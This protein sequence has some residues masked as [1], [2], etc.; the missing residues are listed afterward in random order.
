M[1]EYLLDLQLFGEGGDGGDGAAD[2]GAAGAEAVGTGEDIPAHIPERARETYRKAMAKNQPKVEP[3]PQPTN[4]APVESSKHVSYQDL[5]KSDEYKDEH[6]AYMDKTISDR[7]KKYKGIEESNKKMNDALSK[8]AIKYGLDAASETFLDDLSNKISE[9]N[10]YYEDYAME[11]DI[12]VN[13]AKEILD[14]KQ[15]VALQKQEENRRAMAE[16]E[17]QKEQQMQEQLNL[18]RQ[19]AER[20]KAVYPSFDLDTEMQNERFRVLCAATQGD[21]LAAYRVI[22]HDELM[23]AQGQVM[24]KQ[25]NQAAANAVKANMARPIENGLSSQASTVTTTDW[26][27][28]SLSDIRKQAAEWRRGR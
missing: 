1:L 14:L 7:L 11:H 3:Q 5:I 23:K 20:T 9:D 15:Q 17:L 18:L 4:E 6:K 25:A 10:S 26:S 12:G 28:A 24:A 19:N 22:H 2:G 13:E 27:K 16:A 8:V 21:T